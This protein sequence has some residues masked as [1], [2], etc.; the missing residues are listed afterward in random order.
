MSISIHDLPKDQQ[1]NISDLTMEYL[2]KVLIIPTKNVLTTD[3]LIRQWIT[4]GAIG[5]C[6]WGR[7][8]IGKTHAMEYISHH[9]SERF[10]KNFHSFIWNISDHPDTEKS[11]Y[12]SIMLALGYDT[13][14]GRAAIII[15][16]QLLNI[17]TVMANETPHRKVVMFIDEAWQLTTGDFSRLMDL[18]NNLALRKVHLC[19]FLFGN[20][21]LNDLRDLL[22][23]Q[24]KNQIIGR[25]Y[26][27]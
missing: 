17:L 13:N 6:V 5:G 25:F 27:S 24:N 1:R 11:F 15:K 7:P 20:K 22:K 23:N 21:E 12:A 9:L 18:Y 26:G 3:F 4:T 14:L 19:C 16:N 8:R 10:G 2:S